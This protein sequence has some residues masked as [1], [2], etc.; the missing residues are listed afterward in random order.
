[1]KNAKGKVKKSKFFSI[2]NILYLIKSAGNITIGNT[3]TY[4]TIFFDLILS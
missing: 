3:L 2:P 4:A 1:M